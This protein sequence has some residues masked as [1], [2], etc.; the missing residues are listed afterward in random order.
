MHTLT[1]LTIGLASIGQAAGDDREPQ[2]ILFPYY[3]EEAAKYAFYLDEKHE[4]RLELQKQPVLTWTNAQNYMGAVFIW[5]FKGRPELIG[6]IGSHQLKPGR[7]NVFREFHS[8]CVQ[9]LQ[10]VTFPD[11]RRWTPKSLSGYGA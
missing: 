6:C 2:R 7:S 1:L 8:L 11:G 3:A 4:R 9:P 10:P 5:T